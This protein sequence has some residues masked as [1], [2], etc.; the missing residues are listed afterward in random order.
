MSFSHS[1]FSTMNTASAREVLLPKIMPHMARSIAATGRAKRAKTSAH[2]AN[3]NLEVVRVRMLTHVISP[4][5][6]CP[7]SL[8]SDSAQVLLSVPDLPRP[9]ANC[10]GVTPLLAWSAQESDGSSDEENDSELGEDVLREHEPE[11]PASWEC[12]I[13]GCTKIMTIG[14]NAR[15]KARKKKRDG[16]YFP[17]EDAWW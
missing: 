2:T 16:T 6:E 8:V 11:K 12:P 17:T 13:E 9:G 15:F 7:Y 4:A 10:S 5:R 3:V 14:V 1:A